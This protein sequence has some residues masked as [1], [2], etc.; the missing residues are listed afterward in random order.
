VNEFAIFEHLIEHFLSLLF[1]NFQ[2]VL[3]SLPIPVN[4]RG[5]KRAKYLISA[6]LNLHQRHVFL[7]KGKV[8]TQSADHAGCMEEN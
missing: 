7:A 2:N 3:R 1:K 5:A 8:L 6:K 4:V